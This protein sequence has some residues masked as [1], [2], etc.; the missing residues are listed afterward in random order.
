VF[1]SGM[2]WMDALVRPVVGDPY[3]Q[4]A[5]AWVTA[6]LNQLAGAD[7]SVV[8][9]ALAEASGLLATRVPGSVAKSEAAQ[10]RS[11][12]SSLQDFNEGSI[13]PGACED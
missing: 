6:R 5:V 2:T 9:A 10:W 12:T 13:G 7:A 11:L 1:D 3:R 8:A 4:L